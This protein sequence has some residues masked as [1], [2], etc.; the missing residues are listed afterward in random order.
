VTP[1]SPRIEAAF[2]AACLDEL[3]AP[4]PGNVH[5]FAEGHGWSVEDFRRSA[6][7]AAPAIAAAGASVGAR[8]L[9]A[10]EATHGTIGHNTNLGIV[11]LCAPLARA[12]ELPASDMAAALRGVLASLDRQDAALAFDAIR[13]AA[14]G[15]LGRSER[16]DVLAPPTTTLLEAMSEAAARDSI[17]RQYV[18]GYSD[19]FALGVPAFNDAM[20]RWSD[21]RDAAALAVYLTFLAAIPDTHIQR[22]HGAAAAMLVR[23]DAAPLLARLMASDRPMSCYPEMLALDASLK[24]R[25]LNPGASADLT[26]AVLFERRLCAAGLPNILQSATKND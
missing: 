1:L 21:D 25:G 8:V 22:K 20:R 10:I 11:L 9:A 14:P 2:I 15:G 26:V 13:L 12:A 6:R 7:V 24:A 18:T 17:A 16:H 3:E 23:G 19:I 5:V 4:K